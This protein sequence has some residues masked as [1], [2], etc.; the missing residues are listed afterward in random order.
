MPD[1]SAKRPDGQL[2]V[3]RNRKIRSHIW[4]GHNHMAPDLAD[5]PPTGFFK[6]LYRFFAG[7]V[8]KV[9]RTV[10]Q[11]LRFQAGWYAEAAMQPFDPQP[12]ARRQ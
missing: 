12:T 3:L 8:G 5:D 9:R 6:S 7:N 4:L 1:E 2:F 11:T 10:R